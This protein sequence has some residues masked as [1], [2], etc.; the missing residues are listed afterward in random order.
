MFGHM[1]PV[2]ES[3]L[4]TSPFALTQSEK[5][6][7]LLPLLAGLTAHH[8][9]ACASYARI[10]DVEQKDKIAPQTIADLPFLPITLFKHRR[11]RSVPDEDIRVTVRSSGTTGARFSSV[12][13]DGTTSRLATRALAATLRPILGE[14][15]QPMLIVDTPT[16]LASRHG[17]GARAAAILGLMPFGR[18]HTFVLNEDLSLNESAFISFLKKHPQGPVLIYGFTYLLWQRF[19]PLCELCAKNGIDLS[20]A[21]L[22]HSGGWKQLTSQAVDNETFKHFFKKTANISRIVN[23]YGMAEMPGTI[24]VEN[25]DGFLYPPAFADIIIRD[26]ADFSPVPDGTPGLIQ[27]VNLVPQSF[28]GHSILT[29]DVGVIAKVDSGAQGWQGKALQFLGRA[30]KAELRGCSNV[31]GEALSKA[32]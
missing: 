10:L 1:I 3:F 23:F 2:I 11:L 8:K 4:Q 32:A 30:P 17:M 6:A 9:A 27:I 5:E 20:R 22:M 24:L 31:I 29:E 19:L 15:R 26:S 21:T 28:P 13:L 25:E 18:D 16:A 7:R 14:T 12:D